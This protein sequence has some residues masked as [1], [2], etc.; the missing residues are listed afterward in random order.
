MRLARALSH[1][2]AELQEFAGTVSGMLRLGLAPHS[3]GGGAREASGSDSDW[4]GSGRESSWREGWDSSGDDL[5]GAPGDDSAH[6]RDPGRARPPRRR[7]RGGRGRSPP[8]APLHSSALSLSFEDARQEQE[9]SRWHARRMWPYDAAALCLGAL[10]HIAILLLPGPGSQLLRRLA[11]RH[12]VLGFC[13]LPPLLLLAHPSSREW[14]F[15][16]RDVV[17]LCLLGGLLAHQYSAVA[18][19]ARPPPLSPLAP[20]DFLLWLPAAA[21]LFQA[22]F[23]WLAPAA[24]AAAAVGVRLLSALCAA[25][26]PAAPLQ[27]C[28]A[29]SAS[30]LAVTVTG[31]LLVVY[32][33]EWRA[34]R[35]WAAARAAA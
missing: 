14:Y 1:H 3:G 24:A 5:D 33:L 25:C 26:Q 22:R 15:S 13:H 7:W 20:T 10:T 6:D 29:R 32:C 11:W 27:R 18:A 34:R 19:Y 16:R 31:A 35:A 23:A 28:V 17:L 2:A 4:S 30:K 21:L 12:W 9:F 8:P